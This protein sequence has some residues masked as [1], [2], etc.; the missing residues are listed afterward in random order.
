MTITLNMLLAPTRNSRCRL[1]GGTFA[2]PHSH[3]HKPTHSLTLT[4]S[5]SLSL[6]H[7]HTLTPL[8]HS[9]TPTGSPPTHPLNSPPSLL[10]PSVLPPHPN[11]PHLPTLSVSRS[12]SVAGSLT[13]VET[14]ER[15][16]FVVWVGSTA[17]CVD[18]DFKLCV[19]T[20]VFFP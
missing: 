20:A 16:D 2:L 10:C 6:T 12:V 13:H 3:T 11:P 8:T 18:V 17:R 14:G 15:S 19:E 5:H 1:R 7:T 9:H 4:H